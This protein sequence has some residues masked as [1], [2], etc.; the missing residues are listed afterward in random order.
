MSRYVL[1]RNQKLK[2]IACHPGP[3]RERLSA[4]VK[5]NLMEIPVV[6]IRIMPPLPIPKKL[7]NYQSFASDMIWAFGCGRVSLCYAP[8]C[9]VRNHP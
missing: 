4:A 8:A 3:R 2:T 7:L 6:I 9:A 1:S 5:E